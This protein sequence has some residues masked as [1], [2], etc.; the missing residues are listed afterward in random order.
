[1]ENSAGGHGF[2]LANG[3]KIV[4]FVNEIYGNETSDGVRRLGASRCASI[5]KR[6]K[7]RRR[8]RPLLLLL[9]PRL[10]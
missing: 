4:E 5:G 2:P 1:M 8:P 9:P 10:R 3:E 7:P 6:R